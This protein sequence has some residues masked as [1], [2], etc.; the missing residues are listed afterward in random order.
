MREILFRGKLKSRK[1]W[2]YGN[3]NVKSDEV[4][5][6]TPDDTLLGKYGQV[7]PETVGQYIGVNDKNGNKIFEGDIVECVFNGIANK[8]IT[9]WD[10]SDTGFKATNGKIHYGREYDYFNA[11]EE[12]V[13][14]G[15]I[16]DNPELLK[17]V[18]E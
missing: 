3:L 14:I 9:V 5:I 18:E 6:I 2:S 10:N 12:V 7:D 13:I 4:C 16:H 17:E 1:E 8:R 15:N 11:C